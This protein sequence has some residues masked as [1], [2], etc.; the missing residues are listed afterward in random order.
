VSLARD[1][2]YFTY[3][4]DA[5][6]RGVDMRIV[7]GDGRL[8]LAATRDIYALIV[9]DAFSSDTIPLHLA[10]REALE[11]YRSHLTPDGVLGF[12]YS[13][14][15]LN[16]RPLLAR[17]AASA[18]PPMSAW[19][20]DDLVLSDVEKNAGKAASK[21][22]IMTANS[23]TPDLVTRG[24]GTWTHASDPLGAPLW[25]DSSANLLDALMLF[26]D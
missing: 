26:A 18:E 14:R 22:G 24:R 10:T 17:L 21:W 23:R 6:R 25:T 3:F 7:L 13:S 1:S 20:R 16:L 11:I 15:Y 12:H 2:G 9:I 19:F 5:S 4:A 8:E